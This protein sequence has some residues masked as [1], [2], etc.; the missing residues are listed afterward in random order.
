MSGPARVSSIQ[1]LREFRSALTI[2][3]DEARSAL[4]AAQG[5]LTRAA[6]RTSADLPRHWQAQQRKWEEQV[7]RA[8]IALEHARSQADMGKSSVDERRSLHHAKESV[9]VARR[10]LSSTKRWSREIEREQSQ[11][12]GQTEPLARMI[13][14][15]IPRAIAR[16]ERMAR[17]LEGYTHVQMPDATDSGASVERS[18]ATALASSKST[19]DTDRYTALRA[20]RP[21]SDSVRDAARLESSSGVPPI[22]LQREERKALAL[23]AGEHPPADLRLDV[24]IS[25]VPE[26]TTIILQ[27]DDPV[28]EADSGWRFHSDPPSDTCTRVPA[29][30]LLG[31][32]PDLPSLARCPAGTLAIIEDDVVSALFDT[33]GHDAW[34][35]VR[36]HDADGE[37]DPA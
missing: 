29:V 23:L 35:D 1:A 20:L 8:R 26:S 21:H 3:A 13:E 32:I 22:Q 2:F 10:K 14:G 24:A 37:E 34:N 7:V 18:M 31:A 9:D 4:D 5:E 17:D 6:Q 28:D 16:L 33:I 30:R 25:I 12:R 27:R 36:T 11:Y 15:D 19:G